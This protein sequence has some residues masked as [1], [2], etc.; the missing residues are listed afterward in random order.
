MVKGVCLGT[1]DTACQGLPASRAGNG[2]TGA[3]S[4]VPTIGW[5]QE[6]CIY[7]GRLDTQ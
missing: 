4:L 3:A 2:R 1:V 7:L 5:G 6:L